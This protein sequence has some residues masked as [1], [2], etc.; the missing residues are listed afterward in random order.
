MRD[1]E[2]YDIQGKLGEGGRGAVYLAKDRQLNRTVA[3]KRL[4]SDEKDSKSAY[5]ALLNESRAL[6]AINNPH[7]I[8]VFDVCQDEDGPYVVME[9]LKG[10]TLHEVVATAPLLE[11]DFLEIAEQALEALIAAHEVQLLHRDIKPGNLMLTWLPSG[12]FN[13]KLLDFGLAKF[14]AAPSVQTVAH[15]KSVFGSI[16]FMAPEQFERTPL[17]QR[18][19][20]YSLGCVFFH[21]LTGDYPFD[22]SNVTEVMASHLQGTHHDLKTLRPDLPPSLC[23]WVT[24][25]IARNPDDRPVNAQ[26]ALDSL[27]SARR[28]TFTSVAPQAI[29]PQFISSP[30]PADPMTATVA[31]PAPPTGQVPAPPTGSIPVPPTGRVPVQ[32]AP[33]TLKSSTGIPLPILVTMG[34]LSLVILGLGAAIYF[35]PEPTPPAPTGATPETPGT[36]ELAD[37]KTPAKG[38]TPEKAEP[39][40]PPAP[41]KKLS[42]A[43]TFKSRDTNKD[44]KLSEK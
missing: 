34:I 10:K 15:D 27:A 37:S 12:R 8:R 28:G 20:L 43:Q 13:L 44:G 19:D 38:A 31:I 36:T 42:P 16:Y 35:R 6:S 3:I 40:P 11:H 7:I 2:R 24:C 18:T 33:T 21:A 41:P 30:G 23:D 22:G 14:S 26:V 5:E 17:D 32:T 4:L 9:H 25:F 1:E 39:K 29:T